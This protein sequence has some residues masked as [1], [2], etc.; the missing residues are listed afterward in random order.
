MYVCFEQEIKF[1]RDFFFPEF[2]YFL[3][4]DEVTIEPVT[5]V[6]E[7][8]VHLRRHERVL[9]EP[10]TSVPFCPVSPSLPWWEC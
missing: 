6:G 7:H 1:V 5:I 8:P 2:F 4:N 10:L 3:I 9:V